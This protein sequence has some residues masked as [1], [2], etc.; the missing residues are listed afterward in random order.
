MQ[1]IVLFLDINMEC[2]CNAIDA[3]H[4][5]LF[6]MLCDRAAENLYRIFKRL[7]YLLLPCAIER[8][9]FVRETLL[10]WR[11]DL[12]FKFAQLPKTITQSVQLA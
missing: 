12:Q 3:T 9:L 5:R 7:S 11:G 8:I 10:I 4:G 1:T 2:Y 6:Q